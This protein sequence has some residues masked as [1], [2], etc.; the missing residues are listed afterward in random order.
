[1]AGFAGPSDHD[2]VERWAEAVGGRDRVAGIHSIYR[3]ATI[4]VAG[5]EGTIKAWHTADGRYRKEER[6]G[7]FARVETFDGAKALV[8]VGDALARELTGPERER[9]VSQAFANTNAIF[10]A[11]FPDRRHGS[12]L[13]EQDGT[14]LLKPYGGI[15]WRV[16]LD[17]STS[18]PSKMTHA[19]GERPVVVDFVSYETVDGLEIESEIRRSPGD[20]RFNAVI[21]FTKTVLNPAIDD[22]LFSM[23]PTPAAG[24]AGHWE[25]AIHTPLEDI[26]VGVDLAAGEG[27]KTVGTFSSPSQKLN[28]FPL[29]SASIDGDAVKLE[30][31]FA[32]PGVRTFDGRMAADG[33][34]IKGQFRIGVQAVPFTLNRS[35]EAQ[36]A[37]PPKSAAIDAK[38]VGAW[39]GSLDIGGQSLP[40]ALTLT[41]HADR[42]ATGTWSAG[43]APQIPV[44]IAYDNGTLTLTTPVTPASFTGSLSADGT[45]LS[46][47]LNEGGAPRAVVFTRAAGG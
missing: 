40:F 9:A 14:I 32:D 12:V 6:G 44:V 3:E 7:N 11:F 24:L 20:P 43:G 38:L 4:Q 39:R 46:G 17:P 19:E 30:L 37:P 29:W 15:D 27:G 23:A 28:G 5:G 34:S 45:Q 18:L 36:I 31:K 21:R 33:L 35:G 42:T 41:N 25:G 10:F 26:A 16:E 1:M 13:V 47:T 2:A 8:Q 22:A